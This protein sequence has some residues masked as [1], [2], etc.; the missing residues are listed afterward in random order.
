MT[1]FK[2]NKY[3]IVV[4]IPTYN[5]VDSIVNTVQKIDKGLVEY[6]SNYD[7]III[8][9]DSCSKDR[10]RQVFNSA[11]TITEKK[12]IKSNRRIQGK[13]TNIFLLL[14]FC[15][16]IK[17]KYVVMIDADIT[18]VEKGWVKSILD[19]IIQKKADFV[20]PIY[21]RNRY[22]GNTTNHF[23]F[24]LIYAQFGKKISQPIGG[25]FGLSSSFIE[26][27]MK[28]R[29]PK[30]SY[31]YGIDIFLSTHAVGA[32][33][34]IKEVFLG[35]K[36]HKP[37]FPKIIPMFRQ[38]AATMIFTLSQYKF[39]E[40]IKTD[41]L[42]AKNKRIDPLIK[43]PIKS[44]VLFLEKYALQ[45][46]QEIPEGE[47]EEYFKLGL[48]KIRKIKNNQIKI[49]QEDWV[50]ILTNLFNC[51]IKYPVKNKIATRMSEVLSPFFFLRV[52]SYFEELENKE[53]D[54]VDKIVSGQAKE[55][56][57]SIDSLMGFN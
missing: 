3:D 49:N 45:S 39:E 18:T 54:D 50:K 30:E 12:S 11:Q 44:K 6:F 22:E 9:M 13:G 43:K 35:R 31:L 21:T 36:I 46:L 37:S 53:K 38:V 8:N 55:L 10:T 34:R 27:I 4:G 7:S 25:D 15:R 19:P 40:I 56:R 47:I 23:C 29:K 26:H 52:L 48:E 17:A 41:K 57:S 28:Q 20:T 14:K 1:A 51:I 33:F 2:K 5:E 16:K 42:I 24:P 32:N